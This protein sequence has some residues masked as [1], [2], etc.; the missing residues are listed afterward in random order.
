MIFNGELY[1][2]GKQG[3]AR[4]IPSAIKW[5]RAGADLGDRQA[6]LALGQT[7][8]ADGPGVVKDERSAMFWIKRAAELGSPRA[9]VVLARFLHE[10]TVGEKNIIAARYWYNQAVLNGFAR[11]DATGL[12]AQ[13]Q[14]FMN[15]WKYADFSPSY[16]YVNEYGEKVADGDDGLLNG[17]VSGMFGAMAEYY[18]HQQELING[19]EFICKK[20]GYRIYGGTVSSSLMSNLQLHQ[21]QII[22]IK[23]YGIISTGMMSGPANADGLG[24]NWP[25]YRIIKDI[26]CSAVMGAVKDAKWQFIGQHA[27]YTAPKDGPFMLALNAI[28]YRNYKGYFDVVIQVPEN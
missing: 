25:E 16:I 21:G 6:M 24:P 5:F 19:L 2:D 13:A 14:T 22:N 28:D 18:G 27:F 1:F 9:M 3:V 26:P 11:P 12:N 7:Y 17:L 10:G 15:F 20:S 4:S 8:L 23:A